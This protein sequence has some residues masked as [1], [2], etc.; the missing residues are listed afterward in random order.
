VDA[1]RARPVADPARGDAEVRDD[2]VGDSLTDHGAVVQGGMGEAAGVNLNPEGVSMF[3]P[4][5]GT[6]P[7]HTGRGTIN[8]LAAI[9][10]VE[11]LLR[12]LGVLE[13]A[14]RIDA[15]IAFGGS[16]VPAM[17]AGELGFSST[18][19]GYLVVERATR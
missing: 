17:R 15:G 4:S 2:K 19:V 9:G 6:A 1:A 13:A 16:R 7:D 14:D 10:A 8:P 18:A 11:L 12:T 3:E 5:G